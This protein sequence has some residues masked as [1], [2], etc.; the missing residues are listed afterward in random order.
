M[1][2]SQLSDVSLRK[3]FSDA[4]ENK[5]PRSVE[6]LREVSENRPRFRFALSSSIQILLILFS[7]IIVLI[8]YQFFKTPFE[9]L[10]YSISI[11]LVL[12]VV[13]RQI[14]P[15]FITWNNPEGKLLFLLPIIRPIYKILPFI[16]DPFEPSFRGKEK[17]KDEMTLTPDSS[18]EKA[19]DDSDDI[20]AFIDVGEAEGII[21]SD[22]RELI[23]KM[24]E[25]GDTE[26]DDIMTPRTEICCIE[27]NATI[28]MA[29][30]MM[31]EE[32]FSRLPGL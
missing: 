19:E 29:R 16:A 23:E 7:V 18:D 24:F 4:E 5:K 1:A 25:F 3:L 27:N 12:T 10:I 17:V 6:F 28:T 8:V 30:D 21:E 15:R 14:L 26:V 13:F 11:S 31:I 22:D 20:Q 2:F 9:M 32:K